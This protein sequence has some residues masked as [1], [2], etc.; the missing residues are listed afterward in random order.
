MSFS[1]VLACGSTST[2]LPVSFG[3][4]LAPRPSLTS[5][6]LADTLTAV[7]ALRSTSWS[8]A[9]S[10]R[11]EAPVGVTVP[12]WSSWTPVREVLISVEV[13]FEHV[14]GCAADSLGDSIAD[15]RELDVDANELN[16]AEGDEKG[17]C[18]LDSAIDVSEGFLS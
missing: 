1:F 6:K 4:S 8:T 11:V 17:N 9:P 16:K 10:S 14:E 7:E 3:S 2:L 13:E 5:A 18:V 15:V 12:V